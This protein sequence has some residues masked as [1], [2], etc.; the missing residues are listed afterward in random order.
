MSRQHL[1]VP[2]EPAPWFTANCTTNPKF[3][4]DSIAGR[5]I[6]LC[7]FGSM[8]RPDSERIVRDFLA[9]RKVF[10]DT[11]ACFFGVSTDPDDQRLERVREMVPGVR[12]FWDFDRAVSRLYAAVTGESDAEAFRPHTLLLD[13][14]MRVVA[15]LPFEASPDTHAVRVTDLLKRLPELGPPSF[16]T[17]Q[18]PVLV[19]PRIF[20][21][22]LCRT[23]MRYYDERGGEGSG[24]MQEAG[25]RTVHVTDPSFKRRRDQQIADENLRK[26]C[27]FRIH[28][29][30]IPEIHKAFQFRAT[31]IER[32]IVACYDATS[33]G[34]FSPHRDNT[35]KGTA[36]RRFAVSLNLNTGEYDGGCLRFPEFGRQLYI[37]PAGGAVVFSCSLLHEATPVTAG[38]RYAFLPFLYDDAAAKIRDQNLA[39]VGEMPGQA[40]GDKRSE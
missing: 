16:A 4:F 7:F 23:L 29:R 27:M 25:G 38:K 39:F 34:F 14:R 32:Y 30:L 35:T 40:A 1:L 33:G 11:N 31:R 6:V 28:D 15:V 9:M 3:H 19:V 37:P 12:F 22:D 13:E 26:A 18:A 2:G 17:V 5:Y 20:E 21:P 36:H 10:D 24:F 8:A